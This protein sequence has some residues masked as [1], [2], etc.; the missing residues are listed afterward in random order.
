[1]FPCLREK[2]GLYGTMCAISIMDVDLHYY[3]SILLI[4]VTKY[5][6]VSI[7]ISLYSI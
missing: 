5:I 3:A 6:I 7:T 1:M 4:K 2:V